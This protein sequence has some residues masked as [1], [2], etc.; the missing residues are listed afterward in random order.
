MEALGLGGGVGPHI[1][2]ER[3]DAGDAPT[4]MAAVTRPSAARPSA[5]RPEPRRH[6]SGFRA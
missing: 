4:R 3:S 2:A 6:V 1:V 5:A